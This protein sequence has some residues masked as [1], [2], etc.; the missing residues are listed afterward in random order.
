MSTGNKVVVSLVFLLLL[1]GGWV[2]LNK[3]SD[4]KDAGNQT[5]EEVLDASDTATP[6]TD[7]ATQ[8]TKTS[9][10]D[11]GT[12]KVLP[13]NPLLGVRGVGDPNAPI[14]IHE[15]FSLTCNHCADF[16]KG[17]YQELKAKYI[18]AGKIYFV[19]EEFPLN[20]PALYGS[21]IA[22]CL[23]QERYL[24]FI[25]ILLRNQEAWAFGGDFKGGLMQNAKL[26]GMSEDEFNKCFEN[27][28]LQQALASNI[29]AAQE[30]W[31]VSSTPTFVLNN[32]ERIIRGGRPLADFE[33]VIAELTG[34]E[35]QNTAEQQPSREEVQKLI[36]EGNYENEIHDDVEPEIPNPAAEDAS[37]APAVTE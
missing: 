2:Y 20:G 15:Y 5:A 31:E 36:E 4:K 22:R 27:D 24:G 17:T 25:D 12:V 30:A 18:D 37:E 11:K 3:V 32:G 35:T 19:Y 7:D 33:T 16:Y 28:D 6:A 29:S 23:P 9:V 21:M 26:A 8:A 14:V 1:I 34:G 10:G 13:V